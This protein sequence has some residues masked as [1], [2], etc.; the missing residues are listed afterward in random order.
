M[1]FELRWLSHQNSESA[2]E[3]D[4]HVCESSASRWSEQFL[5]REIGIFT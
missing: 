1:E 5:S 4:R 2:R 3:L